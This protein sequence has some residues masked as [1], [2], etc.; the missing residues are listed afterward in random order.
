MVPFDFMYFSLHSLR[1]FFFFWWQ[2]LLIQLN[3]ICK[4]HYLSAFFLNPLGNFCAVE[5]DCGNVNFIGPSVW[6]IYFHTHTHTRKNLRKQK[7]EESKINFFPAKCNFDRKNV[8]GKNYGRYLRAK[9]FMVAQSAAITLHSLAEIMD[10]LLLTSVCGE[11]M[12]NRVHLLVSKNQ[13]S[14]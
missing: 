9:S 4:W 14:T 13:W 5:N 12:S 8:I 7:K 11:R 6:N 10:H 1:C 2:L 3:W